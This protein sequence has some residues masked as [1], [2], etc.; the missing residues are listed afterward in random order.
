MLRTGNTASTRLNPNSDLGGAVGVTAPWSRG[1]RSE[2]TRRVRE[3][4]IESQFRP[5]RSR[6]TTRAGMQGR[7]NATVF[8]ER[9][10]QEMPTDA[11]S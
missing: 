1:A 7:S 2:R 6:V 9:C 5:R 11:S 3:R 10:T 8:M 4:Q